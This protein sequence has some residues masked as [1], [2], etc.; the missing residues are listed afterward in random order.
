MGGSKERRDSL[1]GMIKEAQARSGFVSEEAISD[2]AASLGLCVSDVYGVATF[3][4]FVSTRPLGRHVIRICKSVPCCLKERRH[5]R[6][7]W[8]G[9]GDRTWGDDR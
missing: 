5:W 1:L 2:M 3:Y 9:I 8:Q 7:D 4:S 6:V